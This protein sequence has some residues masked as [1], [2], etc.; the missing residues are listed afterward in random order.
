MDSLHEKIRARAEQLWEEQ[1]R[2]DG[3]AEVHWRRAERE[4][5]EGLNDCD[6]DS[7]TSSRHRK[8]RDE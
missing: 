2:P 1:G 6:P 3:Q 4:V 8:R 5:R 7:D